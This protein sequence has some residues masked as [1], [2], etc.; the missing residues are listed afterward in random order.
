MNG[1]IWFYWCSNWDPASPPFSGVGVT[2]FG[3]GVTDVLASMGEDK[4]KGRRGKI[5]G[6]Q[7]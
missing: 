4:E 1:L 7:A 6:Y 5:I 2:D 3:V